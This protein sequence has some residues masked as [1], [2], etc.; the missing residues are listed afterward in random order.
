M[1]KWITIVGVYREPLPMACPR[2]NW[3]KVLAESQTVGKKQDP[4]DQ[5]EPVVEPQT[6]KRVIGKHLNL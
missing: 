4:Q 6:L 5:R 1:S 2:Q 3:Q